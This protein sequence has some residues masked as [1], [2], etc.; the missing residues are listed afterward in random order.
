MKQMKH[1][2]AIGTAVLLAMTSAVPLAEAHRRGGISSLS[3][4]HS[5][6]NYGRSNYRKHHPYYVH[7]DHHHHGR[8]DRDYYNGDN[9]GL[10]SDCGWLHCHTAMPWG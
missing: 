7:S 5:Y 9:Y 6:G 10:G 3:A 2:F 8:R 4:D 1:V